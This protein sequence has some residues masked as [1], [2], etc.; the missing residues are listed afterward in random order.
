DLL[1]RSDVQDTEGARRGIPLI[2]GIETGH[3]G[4]IAI[5]GKREAADRKRAGADLAQQPARLSFPKLNQMSLPGG[6]DECFAIGLESQTQELVAPVPKAS[7]S[8]PGDRSR[9]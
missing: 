4:I 8:Q 5:R 1:A 2:K 3:G 6:P 9:R 7:R